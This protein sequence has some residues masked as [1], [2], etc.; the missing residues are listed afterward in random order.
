[1]AEN[2]DVY[3]TDSKNYRIRRISVDGIIESV[4]GS[5]KQMLE[6]E[7]S[8]HLFHVVMCSLKCCVDK[9]ACIYSPLT[10]DI[11]QDLS[12]GPAERVSLCGIQ[13]SVISTRQDERSKQTRIFLRSFCHLEN[14][15][16]DYLV[17]EFA[18]G[19][20]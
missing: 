7:V 12:T 9:F 2:G 20:Y 16:L 5:G 13:E 14:A 17:T 8:F 4:A 1:M 19:Y 10:F 15:Y 18:V 6:G 3:F 11:H